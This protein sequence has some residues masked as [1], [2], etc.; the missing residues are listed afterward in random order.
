VR[1][2]RE[3]APRSRHL[4]LSSDG[5]D[6]GPLEGAPVLVLGMDGGWKMQKSWEI[7]GNQGVFKWHC[8]VVFGD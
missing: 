6:V 1:P 8:F 4:R 5:Q 2:Q 3:G 7:V